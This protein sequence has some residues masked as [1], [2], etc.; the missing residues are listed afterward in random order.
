MIM[1]ET[2]KYYRVYA[3]IDLDAVYENMEAISNSIN[4]GTTI[5]AVVKADGYGHG[6]VPVAKTI[7]EF[8]ASYA[9]ATI[10]EA[11]NLREH[12]IVKPIYILGHTHQSMFKEAIE[13][14]ID[15][16][17]YDEETAFGV[18]REALALNKK[19]K[20]QIKID[21]G[22]SRIGFDD[23]AESIE[24]IAKISKMKN[25]VIN[26][27][28]TH[29][30]SAD[31]TDKTSAREQFHR[32][33]KVLDNLQKNGIKIPVIHCSN[34]ACII[35]L[36]EMNF[37]TVRPGIAIYGLYP[38]EEVEHKV[39]AL[40]PAL[41]L[42]SHIIQLK[43]VKKGT[44]VSY[45]STYIAEKE[46]V[47]ATIPIGYGDGYPRSLSN[48]GYVLIRG[49]KAP[50]TGRVCMDQIMV[51]VTDIPGVTKND[52]VTLIGKDINDVITVESIA[53]LAG[54]FNYEFV[55]GIGKRVPRVYFKNNKI[56]CSKDYFHDMYDSKCWE[57]QKKFD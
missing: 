2:E 37:S 36:P 52:V 8:V 33:E 31:E 24:T 25:L 7:D 28:F 3:G 21:T 18:E 10:H 51:D 38:S 17:L 19:A 47:I 23:S 16:T 48:K 32:F 11:M 29:F 53:E 1:D 46:T 56:V 34:S 30:S 55:C 20:I 35:D 15:L 54:S 42:K 57:N 22:M 44:G 40:K 45:G 50:I 27:I 41:F 26:G 14:E 9:V 49:Q 6:A 4:P 43:T 39:L 12:G 13:N 5:T